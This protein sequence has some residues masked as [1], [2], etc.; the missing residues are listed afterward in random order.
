MGENT[1]LEYVLVP[2]CPVTTYAW[3]AEMA[4]STVNQE[5]GMSNPFSCLGYIINS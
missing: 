4:I 5:D 1:I 3:P 2:K